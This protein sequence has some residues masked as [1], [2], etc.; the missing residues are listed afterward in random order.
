M[1]P[2]TVAFL[3]AQN[4]AVD[5]KIWPFYSPQAVERVARRVAAGDLSASHE[6]PDILRA[7]DALRSTLLPEH[8]LALFNSG[9]SALGAA[10][11]SLGLPKGAEVLVPSNTFRATVTPLLLHQ[12][13]PILCEADGERGGIDL[14]HAASLVTAKTRA[15]VVTHMWG[16]PVDMNSIRSFARRYQ[17]AVIEDCSHAH[18]TRWKNR[19]VG[20][21]GDIAIFSLGTTKMVSGGT[22]GVLATKSQELFERAILWGLPKHR[23]LG[24]LNDP[25]LR[26][27]AR[28]GL[29]N[30]L[31]CSPL[32]AILVQDH[33]QRLDETLRVKN[34]NIREFSKMLQERYEG[35]EV[36]SLRPE[37]THGTL[38]KLHLRMPIEGPSAASVVKKL[39][40]I[41]VRARI[42][43][44]PLH[45]EPLF[46]YPELLRKTSIDSIDLPASSAKDFPH[47]EAF[48]NSLVE[49]DTRDMYSDIGPT[50]QSWK[51]MNK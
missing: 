20:T 44:P 31:R 46:K 23:I 1:T 22:A 3:S 41:G 29:G 17:V 36:L 18:G 33:L 38:Y 10:Y 28:T 32:S 16:H 12:L 48:F 19:P 2:R 5:S 24:L 34:A 7:E 4:E 26:R 11:A 13:N 42:P 35:A 43:A 50:I 40:A 47:T 21:V 6:D 30:N 25:D 14:T 49:F 15:I 9:T 27:L 39:T 37:V 51:G 45:R 8:K